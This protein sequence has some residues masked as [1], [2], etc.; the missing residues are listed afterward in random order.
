MRIRKNGADKDARAVRRLDMRYVT[1]EAR[2]AADD[3]SPFVFWPLALALYGGFVFLAVWN[4]PF[5]LSPGER[6]VAAIGGIAGADLAA[7]A[8]QR[9]LAG[10]GGLMGGRAQRLQAEFARGRFRIRLGD[11]WQVFDAVTPHHF[12]MREHSARYEEGRA[13]ERARAEGLEQRPDHYRRAWQIVLDHG[14]PRFVLAAVADEEA[15][16]TMIRELQALDEFAR[17]AGGAGTRTADEA[18]DLA[19]PVGSRPTLD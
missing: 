2:Y 1:P 17:G 9:A 5:G 4:N 18:P 3:L 7:Y 19:A 6:M 14:G 10:M 15:A 12:A 11:R 13:E 16:R 8:L